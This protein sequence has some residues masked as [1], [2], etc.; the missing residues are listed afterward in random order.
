MGALGLV[1]ILS[2]VWGSA[3]YALTHALKA[4]LWPVEKPVEPV[5]PITPWP[6][7]RERWPILS[8]RWFE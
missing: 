2:P 4:W 1:L 6:A 3:L 5:V 8:V 7:Q